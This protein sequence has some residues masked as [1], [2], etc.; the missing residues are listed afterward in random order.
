MQC[1]AKSKQSGERCKRHAVP[2]KEVCVIHGGKTPT[3]FAL[4]Q[5]RTAHYSK[6]L[7]ARMVAAYE[8]ALNDPEILD[9]NGSIALI[10]ARL[11]DLL[12][13]V[14]TGESGAAWRDVNK[15]YSDLR[16]LLPNG[17][18]MEVLK[19]LAK[20]DAAIEVAN[21]DYQAWSEIS[22]ILDDRRKHV[23]T[24]QKLETQGERAVSANELMT[25]MGAVMKLIQTTVSNKQEQA[26]IADGIERLIAP[27][28]AQVH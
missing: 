21:N 18:H 12:T 26:K 15:A 22:R 5:T 24:K 13:R 28:G 3:G 27:R 9:L 23:E 10:D 14:D 1:K 11:A 17:D 8:A 20:M 2:G 25:F 6:A 19:A 4:P 7:P 16:T